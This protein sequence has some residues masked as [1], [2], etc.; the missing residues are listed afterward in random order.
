MEQAAKV[1][2]QI[3]PVLGLVLVFVFGLHSLYMQ[4][5]LNRIWETVGPQGA[6]SV[7]GRHSGEGPL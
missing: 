5:H 1:P 4:A 3:E 7:S 2:S 6:E